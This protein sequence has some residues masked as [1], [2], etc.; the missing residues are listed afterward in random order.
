MTYPNDKLL[1][2]H[3]DK[4]DIDTYISGSYPEIEENGDLKIKNVKDEV[5]G[6]YQKGVWRKIRYA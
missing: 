6:I 5:V 4:S 1:N 2:I 3:Y